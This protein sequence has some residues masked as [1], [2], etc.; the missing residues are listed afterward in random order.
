M[1]RAQVVYDPD[2]LVLKWRWYCRTGSCPA[3][4]YFRTHAAA[5]KA[6]THH[7]RVEKLAKVLEREG[8]VKHSWR[9]TPQC[10]CAVSLAQVILDEMV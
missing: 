4:G 8:A 7:V 3:G 9:C 2:L 6:A 10:L 5:I 1:D